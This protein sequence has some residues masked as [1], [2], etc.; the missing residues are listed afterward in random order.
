MDKQSVREWL[1]NQPAEVLSEFGINAQRN[2]Q[3]DEYAEMVIEKAV[4]R[5]ADRFGGII[6][7]SAKETAMSQFTQ[8]LPEG[9][10]KVVRERFKDMPPDH[11]AALAAEPV[12]L[13][14]VRESA[15][16]TYARE[17][18]ADEAKKAE[19][20]DQ[21]EGKKTAATAQV[22]EFKRTMKEQMGVEFTDDEAREAI[23][24]AEQMAQ[25]QGV[26]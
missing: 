21:G 6:G 7:A 25:N 9:A 19:A 8:G 23:K 5:M 2:D 16:F 12:Y 22:E 1:A 14:T 11:L 15:E 17:R 20:I 3:A 26:M 10:Q 13:Q 18:E 24:E 4:Q